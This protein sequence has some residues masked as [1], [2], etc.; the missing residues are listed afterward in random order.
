MLYLLLLLTAH[1]HGQ[2]QLSLV[3]TGNELRLE[4]I[5]PGDDI[6]PS[7]RKFENTDELSQYWLNRVSDS[8]WFV[9]DPGAQ[10]V[11]DQLKVE[12]HYQDKRPNNHPRRDHYDLLFSMN[13]QCKDLSKSPQLQLNV[14]SEMKRI[15]KLNVL[16]LQEGAQRSLVL[17]SSDTQLSLR[18]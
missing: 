2:G 10:C 1:V 14:W 8:H 16:L 7:D 18:P 9:L 12:V 15:H 6:A 4:L 5:V 11:R 17:K 13:H 3:A